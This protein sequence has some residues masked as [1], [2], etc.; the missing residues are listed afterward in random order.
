MSTEAAAEVFCSVLF[1]CP[2]GPNL[3]RLLKGNPTPPYARL[4]DVVRS[5][6]WGRKQGRQ[7]PKQGG[8]WPIRCCAAAASSAERSSPFL[9]GSID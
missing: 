1:L 9:G 6:V 5:S 4:Q 2:A 8:R 7:V 3:R